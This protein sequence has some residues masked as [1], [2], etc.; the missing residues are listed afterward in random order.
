MAFPKTMTGAS[1]FLIL[2]I[3]PSP[4]MSAVPPSSMAQ[5]RQ[6]LS[7]GSKNTHH[8][9]VG[10]DELTDGGERLLDLLQQLSARHGTIHFSCSD[11]VEPAQLTNLLLAIQRRRPRLRLSLCSIIG[12]GTE[13][14]IVA[15]DSDRSIVQLQWH[16]KGPLTGL[17]FFKAFS[18]VGIWN[19]LVLFG[20][21]ATL[22]TCRAVASHPN[23]I[24]SWE[25]IHAGDRGC[26]PI[27][28][29]CPDGRYGRWSTMR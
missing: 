8:W 21:H 24:H 15:M 4:A 29:R 25:T 9:D 18:R 7:G 22:E 23:I 27:Q 10:F 13:P 11:E 16:L 26:D 6:I 2:L 19:H 17:G 28:A 14:E 20:E 5:V 1:P 12:G 3:Q